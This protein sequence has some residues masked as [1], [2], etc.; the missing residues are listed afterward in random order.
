[1]WDT[2]KMTEQLVSLALIYNVSFTIIKKRS[3]LKPAI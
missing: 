3:Y 1:L 2:L